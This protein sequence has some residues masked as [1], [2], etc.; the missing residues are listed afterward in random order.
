MVS[1]RQIFL[2]VIEVFQGFEILA[3]K[4]EEYEY[5][6]Y[7]A[8]FLQIHD[9]IKRDAWIKECKTVCQHRKVINCWWNMIL[10]YKKLL[11]LR[12]GESATRPES[13]LF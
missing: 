9:Q 2:L 3:F 7:W 1:S 13:H 6:R 4:H 10:E 5:E 12:S 11:W 8:I